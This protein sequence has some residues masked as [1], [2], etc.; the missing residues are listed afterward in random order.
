MAAESAV[1]A[2]FLGQQ[3]DV[4]RSMG[5]PGAD[6]PQQYLGLGNELPEV[7]GDTAWYDQYAP[8]GRS[9]RFRGSPE[10]LRDVAGCWRRGGE[11]L[12]RF[13]EDAQAHASTAS[14]AHSGEA[15]EA[16]W[17]YFR[18]S[19]G[20]GVPPQRAQQD[21]PLVTNLVAACNQLAK[22]CDSYAG[23]AQDAKRKIQQHHLDPFTF[24][25]PW[26][27]PMFGGNG[28]DG[29][30]KDVVLDDPCIH[31]LGDGRAHPPG[32]GGCGAA[33]RSVAPGH[34]AEAAGGKASAAGLAGG[35]GSALTGAGLA[36]RALECRGDV[37]ERAAVLPL[38][39]DLAVVRSEV[40]SVEALHGMP[41]GAYAPQVIWLD[42]LPAGS[43]QLLE[44]AARFGTGV[45]QWQ[46]GGEPQVLV[47]VQPLADVTVTAA[48]WCP[49]PAAC[50]RPAR[51]HGMLGAALLAGHSVL[52][53][54]GRFGGVAYCSY[55]RAGRAGWPRA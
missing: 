46:G 2:S 51:R 48:G 40:A 29:G 39:V 25:M 7:A 4:T 32:R 47:P 43:E 17:Q 42:C 12:L 31:Q 3:G 9:D 50:V 38:W 53:T 27:Q 21:E 20:L 15:A 16:F 26:D 28:Y 23:H 49:V 37:V 45:V 14:K 33:E 44:E 30:L 6:C 34:A 24:D 54:R 41:F 10:K 5:D 55:A 13:L 19:V 11:L 52:P 18:N 36:A 22:A 35:P 1:V 8:G